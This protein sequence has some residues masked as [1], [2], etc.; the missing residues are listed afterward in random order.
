MKKFKTLVLPFLKANIIIA[1]ILIMVILSF[2][3]VQKNEQTVDKLV[4]DTTTSF[5]SVSVIKG[6]ADMIEGSTLFGIE[7]GDVVQPVLDSVNVVWKFLLCALAFWGCLKL[8]IT[9][10]TV[11]AI[12]LLIL[13]VVAYLMN[14]GMARFM[15]FCSFICSLIPF[16]IFGTGVIMNFC[17]EPLREEAQEHFDRVASVFAMDGL[18]REMVEEQKYEEGNEEHWYDWAVRPFKSATIIITQSKQN[19]TYFTDKA[20][21][22]LSRRNYIMGNLVNGTW[23]YIVVLLMNSILIPGLLF[24]FLYKLGRS[25]L[26]GEEKQIIVQAPSPEQEP[27][28]IA[29]I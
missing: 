3:V 5:I 19:I 9:L 28:L 24:L 13:A 7:V 23:K 2:A 8:F 10:P 14:K 6:T 15:M 21:E 1:L 4:L 25:V 22:I 12:A 16:I 26:P 27:K 17:T 18:E 20:K 11:L 29:S